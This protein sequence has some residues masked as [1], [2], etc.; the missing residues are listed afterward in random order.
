MLTLDEA[1]AKF[2][3]RQ[4]L[5]ERE[6]ED[7]SLR[8]QEVRD[9]VAADLHV[10]RDFLTGS[11]A[12]WTKTK[13]LKDVDVFCVLHEDER[14][15]RERP[16]LRILERIEKILAPV[17]GE[18]HVTIDRMA[19]TV[20]F[21]VNV[22]AA[23][24]SDDKVLSI[25]VVPAFTNDGH[26]EIPDATQGGWIE[27]DPE[28]HYD[29][30][31]AAHEAH[32]R[33]W[34]PLVRMIKKWNRH[35]GRPVQPSFLLEVMA[36]KLLVPP[37]SGGYPYELKAFFATAADC[38]H[39]TWPD[40]AGLGPAV[41]G[42]MTGAQKDAARLVLLDA[43]TTVTRAIRLKQQGRTEDALRTW[44]TLFGPQFPLS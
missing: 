44:R 33:E 38:I 8:H 39:D 10:E 1:F 7:V 20:D 11:Y 35:Q 36:L 42:S 4:E 24:D 15:Y 9:L 41:N 21:G 30:A 37:F 6:Q 25:D 13:P 18:E 2:K 28:I 27:T 26:Y 43:E 14:A 23:D 12:R 31:V 3:S 32:Q 40:P 34:K 16:P 19:V 17:Y 29:L 22:S 5:T